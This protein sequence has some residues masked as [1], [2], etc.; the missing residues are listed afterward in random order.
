MP[1]SF[2][3]KT[4]RQPP[5]PPSFMYHRRVNSN[6]ITVVAALVLS[7]TGCMAPWSTPFGRGDKPPRSTA[8]ADSTPAA[9]R[10]PATSSNVDP[11][12]D[13]SGVI[14]KI[15][16]VRALDP[17]A[18]PRLMEQLRRTPPNEWPLVAEQFRATLALHQQLT[19]QEHSSIAGADAAALERADLGQN[20]IASQN[21]AASR[22]PPSTQIG[23]LLDPKTARSENTGTVAQTS[24][25]TVPISGSET[26]TTPPAEFAE[27]ASAQAIKPPNSTPV[28]Q[29]GYQT[30][31][32]ANPTA[33]QEIKK[34]EHSG[35]QPVAQKVP[36]ANSVSDEDWQKMVQ[37]AADDLSQHVAASPSTTAEIHQHV[38]LRILRLLQGDTEKALE[39][40][41]HISPAEQD[42]WSRQLFALATYLDHHSQPDDKRRAAASVIHLD[43]ALSD[44]RELGSL[45]VRN[46]SFCKNVYGYGAFEPYDAD[47]F[48][49]GQQVSLYVEVDNYHSVSNQ[50]GYCTLLGAT[51]EI[52]DDKGKRISGGEFPDVDDCCRSRRRDF[53]IQLGL[54]MPESLTPGHYRLELVV[55]DRQSDKLGHATAQFDVKTGRK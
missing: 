11:T 45:S 41:P 3:K 28:K 10:L 50:K 48:A 12:A 49:P 44:L 46:L 43:E 15:D 18:E 51:Y 35:E 6:W 25:A 21:S 36:L 1:A 42:Y 34:D 55:K 32:S 39:P 31:V 26:A 29:A 2:C 19:A 38:S 33:P 17:A 47:V 54:T 7:S 24:S 9:T 40:I 30:T 16:E 53:H 23:A 5:K 14:D 22:Q 27:A 52:L 20:S 8:M 13:L 4:A 37:K